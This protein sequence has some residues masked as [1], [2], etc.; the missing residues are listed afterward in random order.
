MDIVVYAAQH[1][2]AVDFFPMKSKGF[3]LMDE[4]R[5]YIAVNAHLPNSEKMEV[6]LHE[7]GHI[8]TNSDYTESVP[9][10]ERIRKEQCAINWANE[11]RERFTKGVYHE[12][13]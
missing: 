9:E 1:G 2:I 11:N 8:M 6:I 13:I 5:Y 12:N 10:S 3:C 7:L 4:G